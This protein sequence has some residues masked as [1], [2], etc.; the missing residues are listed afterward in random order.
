[1]LLP[2]FAMVTRASPEFTLRASSLIGL[3]T[4][5]PARAV[6]CMAVAAAMAAAVAEVCAHKLI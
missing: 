3:S 1:M 4:A 2:P 5:C 6:E